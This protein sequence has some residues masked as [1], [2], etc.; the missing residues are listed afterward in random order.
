MDLLHG[1]FN[2]HFSFSLCVPKHLAIGINLF[3][4]ITALLLASTVNRRRYDHH[5][6]PFKLVTTK[7]SLLLLIYGL[8]CFNEVLCFLKGFLLPHHDD[9]VVNEESLVKLSVFC[10][11]KML[12]YNHFFVQF[13]RAYDEL[14]LFAS[15]S[16]L[17]LLCITA[18]HL[19]RCLTAPFCRSSFA[20]CLLQGFSASL[21]YCVV[22]HVMRLIGVKYALNVQHISPLKRVILVFP[23]NETQSRFEKGIG[24]G[25]FAGTTDDDDHHHH[26]SVLE[27]SSHFQQESTLMV[28][29]TMISMFCFNFFDCFL[30][31]FYITTIVYHSM[32]ALFILCNLLHI[33]YIKWRS[34]SSSAK[35]KIGNSN[36]CVGVNSLSAVNLVVVYFLFFTYLAPSL[37]VLLLFSIHWDSAMSEVN[38]HLEKE[39]VDIVEFLSE[40]LV[41]VV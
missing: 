39:S 27:I 12:S 35:T 38:R 11:F 26:H 40:S 22:Y 4:T 16:P 33:L 34:S 32:M 1:Q 28:R 3:L 8:F 41:K 6:D 29:L 15:V 23:K 24:N 20:D 36:G 18:H 2:G 31:F 30:F 14:Q 17:V 13:E 9:Q 25:S 21:A 37:V 7:S 5:N 19:K 10:C